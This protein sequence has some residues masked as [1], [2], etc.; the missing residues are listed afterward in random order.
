MIFSRHIGNYIRGTM[1]ILCLGNTD[2]C[3][4]LSGNSTQSFAI[5]TITLLT[6]LCYLSEI[7]VVYSYLNTV[8][9]RKNGITS[10]NRV[11]IFTKFDL[12]YQG[13]IVSIKLLLLLTVRLQPLPLW[14]AESSPTKVQNYLLYQKKLMLCVL[15]APPYIKYCRIILPWRR[16]YVFGSHII[17]WISKRYSWRLF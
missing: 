4:G 14:N 13:R 12:N 1:Y 7:C 16:F 15:N 17:S 11:I 6:T 10:W 9:Q 2:C 8:F 3:N 5:L